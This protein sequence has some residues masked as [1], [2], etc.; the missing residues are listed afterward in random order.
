VI[1]ARSRPFLQRELAKDITV[2]K[3][4]VMTAAL[5]S[6][7]VDQSFGGVYASIQNY[8]GG[9]LGASAD[10]LP[11]TVIGFNTF[12]WVTLLLTPWL[13]DRFGRRAIFGIGHVTFGAL[14]LYLATT[15]SLSGFMIGRCVEGIA[16]GTFFV[17]AVATVLTLF[18][19]GLRGIAFS[20]FSVISL[21]GVAAG[22]FIGGWFIDHAYWRDAFVLYALSAAF[23]GTIIFALLE[24]PGP[25]P[26]GRFDIPGVAFVFLAFSCF[27]YASAFGERR[28][29][30]SSPDIVWACLLSAVG[31]AGFIWREL[32][33]DRC[34]FIQLRLFNIRNLAVGSA[35]GFG[36]GVPLYGANL[37]LQYAQTSLG[38]PPSTAG[39]LLLL[40]IPAIL[41]VAPFFVLL[42]N[43]DRLDVRVPVTLG[44]VLVPLSYALLVPRTTSESDFWT[45]A[46]AIVLSGAG[47]ASLF[48]PIA[49]VLV[50]SLPTE[51]RA[52]GIAIFK[53][54]LLLGGS[55]AA[56]A[57]AVVY[58]HS[59]AWYQALLAGGATLGHLR[60][61]GIVPSPSTLSALIGEQAAA[62]AYADN[63]KVVALATLLNLPLILFLRKPETAA[64][65][66]APGP[67]EAPAARR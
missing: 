20:C 32:C 54:V 15:I 62:L 46:L 21:T 60:P 19:P 40:R 42:V 38:F 61:I 57:L 23:A 45:F 25:R 10:E 28:G 41:L 13:V 48:S 30:L 29:W 52:E 34:G 66:P 36:L 17:C 64:A 27:E 3:L 63:S 50:R 55:V 58:D 67:T 37:F 59:W 39:A 22:P 4:L 51:V 8:A 43:S 6:L 11:W 49:N 2:G 47:F 26:T 33:E 44:F 53:M 14:T 56:T 7:F 9:T 16:Q 35:L 24:A 31:F 1:A 12:Y 5:V 65:V 18:G